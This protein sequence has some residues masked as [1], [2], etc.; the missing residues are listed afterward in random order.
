[1][2][3][4]VASFSEERLTDAPYAEF[5]ARLRKPAGF[6]HL[7]FVAPFMGVDEQPGEVRLVWVRRRLAAEERG[8]LIL[9][10]DPKG[11]FLRLE[12]QVRGWG[13]FLVLGLL[14]WNSDELLERL[15]DE[16]GKMEGT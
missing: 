5:A 9:R 14:R 7:A 4:P 11:A 6:R 2:K 12:G 16:F 8:T 13:C 1:M 15:V 10:P 3:V